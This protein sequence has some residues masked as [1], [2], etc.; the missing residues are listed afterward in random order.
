MMRDGR[1]FDST[2]PHDDM[3]PRWQ[4]GRMCTAR[5]MRSGSEQSEPEVLELLHLIAGGMR[6]RF[7]VVEHRT[8][9]AHIEPTAARFAFV[10][11]FG[12][13][14]RRS[15]GS[16]AYDRPARDDWGHA[17]DLGHFFPSPNLIG[18]SILS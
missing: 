17:C 2:D 11:V 9:I 4:H 14:Q 7:F 16:L 6:Q 13:A 12:L 5:R 15:A 3:K 1:K 18:I 10:K 8:E